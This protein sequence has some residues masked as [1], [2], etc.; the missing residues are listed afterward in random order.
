MTAE[1]EPQ[2]APR[3]NA[4]SALLL[5]RTA[6]AGSRPPPP[7]LG[8]NS[9]LN[10]MSQGVRVASWLQSLRSRMAECTGF[11]SLNDHFVC[12]LGSFL[13][14]SPASDPPPLASISLFP[15][16]LVK[17]S[18]AMSGDPLPETVLT[19]TECVCVCVWRRRWSK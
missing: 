11:G 10:E 3:S 7:L 2:G 16:A 14:R 13:H 5:L 4:A 9:G 1:Q 8:Q 19:D 15:P 6:R 12:G 17:F 18:A